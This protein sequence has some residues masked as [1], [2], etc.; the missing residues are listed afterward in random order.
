MLRPYVRGIVRVCDAMTPLEKGRFRSVKGRIQIRRILFVFR[1]AFRV[2]PD[3]SPDGVQFLAVAKNVFVVVAL[4]KRNPKVR[5][6]FME[7]L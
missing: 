6:V 7:A 3:V 5:F 2:C 1:P 4:P